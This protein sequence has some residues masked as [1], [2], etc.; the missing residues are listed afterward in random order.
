MPL[1][2][3]RSNELSALSHQLSAGDDPCKIL[4]T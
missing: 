3:G 2:R 4:E 1:I